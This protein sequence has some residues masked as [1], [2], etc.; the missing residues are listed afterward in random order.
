MDSN[1][2]MFKSLKLFIHL[3]E[4]QQ[5]PTSAQHLDPNIVGMSRYGFIVFINIG[6]DLLPSNSKDHCQKHFLNYTNNW[7]TNQ[8]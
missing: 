8:Q 4:R 5:V 2:E 6:E 3:T 1:T 7:N